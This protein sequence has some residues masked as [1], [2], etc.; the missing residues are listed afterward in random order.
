MDFRLKEPS[1]LSPPCSTDIR[2]I[3]FDLVLLFIFSI[4]YSLIYIFLRVFKKNVQLDADHD[5]NVGAEDLIHWLK[6]AGAHGGYITDADCLALFH[7]VRVFPFVLRGRG[8]MVCA[9]AILII[10]IRDFII[11]L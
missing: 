1:V 9:L 7:P 3:L 6:V 10:E 5:G 11:P 4:S 8:R 2:P